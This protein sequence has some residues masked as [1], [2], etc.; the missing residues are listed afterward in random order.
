MGHLRLIPDATLDSQTSKAISQSVANRSCRSC[1]SRKMISKATKS[2]RAT[3][4]G[5]AIVAVV[6]AGTDETRREPNPSAKKRTTLKKKQSCGT[7]LFNFNV[8]VRT[9]RENLSKFN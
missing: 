2:I 5:R 3:A 9:L 8:N 7:E 6:V 4:G 1:I